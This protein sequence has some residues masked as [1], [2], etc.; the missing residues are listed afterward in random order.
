[1]V[2]RPVHPGEILTDEL[3]E[4]GISAARLAED[5]SIPANR[6]YQIIRGQRAVTADTALRLGRWFGMDADFWMNLQKLYDLRTA[7]VEKGA[8]IRR[9]VKV[10][11]KRKEEV[12]V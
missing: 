8:E 11:A 1:M 10:R 7:E 6:L 9:T 3:A 4:L 5:L 2:L 12:V